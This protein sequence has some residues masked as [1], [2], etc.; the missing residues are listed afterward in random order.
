[1]GSSSSKT[2]ASTAAMQSGAVTSGFVRD[3]RSNRTAGVSGAPPVWTLPHVR[4]NIG[5]KSCETRR[6]APEKTPLETAPSNS[7]SRR[8][9]ESA[10]KRGFEY[11]EHTFIGIQ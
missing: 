5:F 2:P 4:S 7:V 6:D 1:M 11:G 10:D 3:A 9:C 8:D